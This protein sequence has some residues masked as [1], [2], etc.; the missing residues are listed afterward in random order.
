MVLVMMMVMMMVLVMVMHGDDDGDADGGGD[1]MCPWEIGGRDTDT[2]QLHTRL[3][4]NG[5]RQ[6]HG[7]GG[8]MGDAT[9]QPTHGQAATPHQVGKST[10]KR[11]SRMT[12]SLFILLF[13]VQVGLPTYCLWLH[14]TDHLC[15]RCLSKVYQVRKLPTGLLGQL[16]YI[17]R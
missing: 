4:A 9:P 8:G 12:S 11:K 3:T 14:L 16:L 15:K 6:V 1:V 10:C 17:S 13:L 2:W 5:K 7:N